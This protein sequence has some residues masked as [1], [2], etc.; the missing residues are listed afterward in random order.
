MQL[1]IKAR[2]FQTTK[3]MRKEE[4]GS[5]PMLGDFCGKAVCRLQ[6]P[7]RYLRYIEK[8]SN[9]KKDKPTADTPCRRCMNSRYNLE[10]DLV[11]GIRKCVIDYDQKVAGC[12]HFKWDIAA[13]EGETIQLYR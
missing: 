7:K 3:D 1:K 4:C 5:C 10:H 2:H 13:K 11:C 12:K 6:H 8:C 9:A